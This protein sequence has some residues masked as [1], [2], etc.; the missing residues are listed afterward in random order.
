MNRT[1][2]KTERDIWRRLLLSCMEA[3]FERLPGANPV[4]HSA[5]ARP[6]TGKPDLRTGLHRADNALRSHSKSNLTPP[7]SYEKRS[8]LWQAH[9]RTTLNRKARTRARSIVSSLSTEAQKLAAEKSKAGAQKISSTPSL[10]ELCI[11]TEILPAEGYI[12]QLRQQFQRALTAGHHCAE[13][14]KMEKESNSN[15]PA[16]RRQIK[17]TALAGSLFLFLMKPARTQN[18]LKPCEVCGIGRVGDD[19]ALMLHI[20]SRF[21]NNCPG[22]PHPCPPELLCITDHNCPV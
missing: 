5:L 7:I 11:S 20:L 22:W 2:N 14:R 17:M 8:S 9:D 13:A 4:N 1:P 18:P 6:V 12:R 15:Q 16:N 19:L 10:L 3:V 21:R